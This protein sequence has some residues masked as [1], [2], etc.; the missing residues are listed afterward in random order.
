MILKKTKS[1]LKNQ[2]KIVK[3][4]S[5]SAFIIIFS[6]IIELCIFNYNSLGG[7]NKNISVNNCHIENVIN[8][9]DVGIVDYISYGIPINENYLK[10]I[11]INYSSSEDFQYIIRYNFVDGYGKNRIID[12]KDEA[13]STLTS[14]ITCLEEKA[15]SLSIL[16][17]PNITVLGF[18][19][20]NESQFNWYRFFII[21][22]LI[23]GTYLICFTKL[24]KVVKLEKV[25]FIAVLI[26]GG[27]LILS[28][29]I[30]FTAPDEAVHFS[31]IY[32]LSFGNTVYN[33]NTSITVSNM[34][35]QGVNSNEE[36]K[37]VSE[38]LNNNND[39]IVSKNEKSSL[40]VKYNQ[41]AYLHMAL[42][43]KIARWLRLDFYSIFLAG[44]FA[45]LIFYALVTYFA[46]KHS[47]VGK[48]LLFCVCAMPTNIFIACAYTYDTVVIA[49]MF[50]GTAIILNELICKDEEM[51]VRKLIFAIIAIVWGCLPKA[52]YAPILLLLLFLPSCKFKTKKQEKLF[53]FS[54]IGVFLVLMS[55]FVLPVITKVA[56]DVYI[57]GDNRGGNTSTSEQMKL[58]FSHPFVYAKLL[59]TTIKD[60]FLEYLIGNKSFTSFFYMGDITGNIH[61][62]AMG[63]LAFVG[64]TGCE[65]KVKKFGKTN[66]IAIIVSAF[67]TICLIWTAL[68][69]SF[70]P[71]G[72]NVING[73]P[74]RYYI[75]ISMLIFSLLLNKKIKHNFNETRYIKVMTVIMFSLTLYCT[76]NLVITQYCL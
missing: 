1:M 11:Q 32:K 13:Y 50:Y 8:E 71:V 27:L 2:L 12:S 42:A 20:K 16:I 39:D 72:S 22:I 21:F 4:L 74:P 19:V 31:R 45:N 9:E 73:V 62:I 66:R 18:E 47:K 7:K 60:T 64:I 35:V 68:Y 69:L 43:M 34:E 63:L 36:K 70:T 3:H 55:S 51:D 54:I 65:K 59:L 48:K 5:V 40:F 17:P 33:T 49:C 61:Y 24:L 57:A 56:N 46:L 23:Q 30:H 76:Y 53:K 52:V 67:I 75:P 58:I 14:A 44:K 6:V 29:P 38:Y 41:R 25:Y 10:K 28:E 15:T 37:L 26:L